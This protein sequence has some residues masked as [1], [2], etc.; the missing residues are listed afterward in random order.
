MSEGNQIEKGFTMAANKLSH[1]VDGDAVCLNCNDTGFLPDGNPC[2]FCSAFE[3]LNLRV[4]VDDDTY[5]H[6]WFE[7]LEEYCYG[8]E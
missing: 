3:E 8:D 6:D 7:E 5:E 2:P 4:E 1:P